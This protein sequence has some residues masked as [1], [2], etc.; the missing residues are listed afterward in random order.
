MHVSLVFHGSLS[1][2][3]AHAHEAAAM[4]NGGMQWHRKAPRLREEAMEAHQRSQRRQRQLRKAL[5]SKQATRP[6][7]PQHA[8]L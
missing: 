3:P 1:S 4:F 2:H 6:F 8:L 5:A 7:R